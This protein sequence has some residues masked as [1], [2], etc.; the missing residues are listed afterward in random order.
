VD[1]A[2]NPADDVTRG[3]FLPDILGPNRRPT[4]PPSLFGT[5]DTWPKL[6]SAEP[7]DGQAQL[8]KSYFCGAMNTSA[9]GSST[10]SF[11]TYQELLDV[12]AWSLSSGNP[13]A[14]D[15]LKAEQEVLRQAQMDSFGEDLS[16]LH[17]HKPLP[18]HSRLLC[19]SP[20]L[21]STSGLIHVG[22]RLWQSHQLESGLIHP[23]V[24][25][26]TYNVTKLIIQDY[27]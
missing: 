2:N 22:G 24:L 20:E 15:Y 11:K 23:I 10:T 5:P 1:S 21:C 26:P 3:K 17:S 4:G 19:L 7:N 8:R 9:N 14:A 25:D 16:R 18:S 12:T 6:Q 27:D 13:S